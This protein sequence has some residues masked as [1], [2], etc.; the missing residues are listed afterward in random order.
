MT[1]L[2][3]RS[4]NAEEAQLFPPFANSKREFHYDSP[5]VQPNQAWHPACRVEAILCTLAGTVLAAQL[6]GCY[7]FPGG[8]ATSNAASP[9][10]GLQNLLLE[11]LNLHVP[12]KYMRP[13]GRYRFPGEDNPIYLYGSLLTD[14]H[15]LDLK[16]G[17]YDGFS[18]LPVYRDM[19][20]PFIP[21]HAKLL[22]MFQQSMSQTEITWR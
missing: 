20:E 16:K 11:A 6:D 9:R 21:A 22:R 10:S 2:T 12:V 4:R 17:L 13:I 5:L 8:L 15:F 1:Q 18:L 14:A 19:P 3:T 7:M